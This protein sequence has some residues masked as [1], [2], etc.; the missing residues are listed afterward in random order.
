MDRLVDFF[1]ELTGVWFG[2]T[3]I[4]PGFIG[5]QRLQSVMGP[6]PVHDKWIEWKAKKQ[7]R[8]RVEEEV[9]LRKWGETDL[10]EVEDHWNAKDLPRAKREWHISDV[11][12]K[13]G[14]EKREAYY[15]L[16]GKKMWRAEDDK[17]S[18]W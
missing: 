10:K 2:R 18:R 13:R 7:E 6:L 9:G 14:C 12:D 17:V 8:Y 4:E 11:L 5:R 15:R 1:E 3:M 16:I